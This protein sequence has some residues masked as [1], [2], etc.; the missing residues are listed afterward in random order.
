MNGTAT[1]QNEKDRLIVSGDLNFATV[2]ALWNESL[3][4][5]KNAENI[6]A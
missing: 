5:L 4:F 3:P 6:E 2:V 1:L